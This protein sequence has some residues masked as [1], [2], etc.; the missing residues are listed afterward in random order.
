MEKKSDLKVHHWL[1]IN[2]RNNKVFTCALGGIVSGTSES[3]ILKWEGGNII[4]WTDTSGEVFLFPKKRTRHPWCKRHSAL[5]P[6]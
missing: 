4:A 1:Q 2:Y 6:I 5:I 3:S